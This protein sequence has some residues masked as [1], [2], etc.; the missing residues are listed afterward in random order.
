[1]VAYH[2]VCP[3]HARENS[4]VSVCLVVHSESAISAF[5]RRLSFP[6]P[7]STG[8]KITSHLIWRVIARWKSGADA[9]SACRRAVK[10]CRHA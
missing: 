4:Y 9:W 8:L 10:A 2:Q 3:L 6:L 7:G 1:M 5:W